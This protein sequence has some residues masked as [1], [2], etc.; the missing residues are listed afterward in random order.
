[1]HEII[2]KRGIP[3]EGSELDQKPNLKEF[4]SA[5]RRAEEYSY[6]A[7]WW[8]TRS[9][10]DFVDGWDR[11]ASPD[12]TD[13]VETL[14]LLRSGQGGQDP[15][16]REARALKR[17][18]SM[19]K[20]AFPCLIRFIDDDDLTLGTT[21]LRLLQELSGRESKALTEKNKAELRKDWQEWLRSDK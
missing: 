14:T 17:L 16:S 13:W 18:K 8:F 10:R 19:N 12:I 6:W 15:D 9:A 21:A 4:Y 7:Q 20:R 5:Q 1:M 2:K 3:V 11:P